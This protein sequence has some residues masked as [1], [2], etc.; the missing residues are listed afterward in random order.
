MCLKCG[1]LHRGLGSHISFIRS[2]TLDKWTEEQ[3]KTME[4]I[5]N[6]KASEYWEYSLP[7][8]F[9]RPISEYEISTFITHKYVDR[10]WVKKEI[11]IPKTNGQKISSKYDTTFDPFNVNGSEMNMPQNKSLPRCFINPFNVNNNMNDPMIIFDDVL[12]SKQKSNSEASPAFDPCALLFEIP[13]HPHESKRKEATKE[14]PK[15]ISKKKQSTL[16][17]QKDP[18]ADLV[19]F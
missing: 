10:L 3:V 13:S 18:F 4:S 11:P 12:P 9:K 19:V 17:K 8:D 5:G 1:S 15:I 14:E 16:S 2:V 7:K 6:K